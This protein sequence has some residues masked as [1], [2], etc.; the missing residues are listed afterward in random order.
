MKRSIS[1]R[2]F[3]IVGLVLLSLLPEVCHSAA[4]ADEGLT[5]KRLEP[6]RIKSFRVPGRIG[7]L[8]FDSKGEKLVT[9]GWRTSDSDKDAMQTWTAGKSRGD[10]RE[11]KGGGKR[12]SVN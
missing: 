9:V 11:E 2:P 1:V 10:I 3:L 12:D 7:S 4:V 5:D 6:A 8:A